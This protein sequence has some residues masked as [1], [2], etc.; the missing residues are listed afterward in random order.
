MHSFA[1]GGAAPLP[2]SHQTSISVFSAVS[3]LASWKAWERESERIASSSRSH[4][5]SRHGISPHPSPRA[6]PHASAGTAG[7]CSPRPGT[8]QERPRGFSGHG[9]GRRR[10]QL[11][12]QVSSPA[13]TLFRRSFARCASPSPCPALLD[14]PPSSP[15]DRG[16]EGPREGRGVPSRGQ[17]LAGFDA[18]GAEWPRDSW[19]EDEPRKWRVDSVVLWVV[20]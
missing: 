19:R 14:P 16:R 11:H 5:S 1:N 8:E 15:W 17:P 18:W 10:A 3:L 9:G 13:P 12:P 2:R 7:P 4:A 20:N 6:L